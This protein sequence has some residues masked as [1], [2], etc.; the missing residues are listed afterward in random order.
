M[1]SL[2]L[3]SIATTQPQ[4][5]YIAFVDGYRQKFNYVFRTMEDLDH[6]PA[7][8]E[9]VTRN[10]LLLAI[11]DGKRCNDAERHILAL[12]IKCGGLGMINVNEEAKF[13]YEISHEATGQLRSRVIDQSKEPVE[14]DTE[15]VLVVLKG[16]FPTSWE[17][18]QQ[19]NI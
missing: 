3:A 10:W 1:K 9:N 7:P 14:F 8:L 16:I 2:P 6:F 11:C 12:P 4:A 18:I 17:G 13:Q 19:R 15:N 5:A